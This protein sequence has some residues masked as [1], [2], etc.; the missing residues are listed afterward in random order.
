MVTWLPIKTKTEW[1]WLQ[2]VTDIPLLG[3]LVALLFS[4]WPATAYINVAEAVVHTKASGIHNAVGFALA[5]IWSA[6]LWKRY[7]TE[8]SALWIPTPFLWL[9]IGA[10]TFFATT[11]K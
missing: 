2:R 11:P 1:R 5:A 9:G 4:A 7:R 8:I 10:L 6:V 3:A